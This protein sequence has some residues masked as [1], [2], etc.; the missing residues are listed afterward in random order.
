MVTRSKNRSLYQCYN[1]RCRGARIVCGKG[2]T[3]GS[4]D[5]GNGTISLLKLKRGAPLEY[6]VCQA[7]IDFASM[8]SP[9]TKKDR[10][11]A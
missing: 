8:G 11:W 3:L 7:C 2:H 5:N 6:S 10:G 1:A 9:L 4:T